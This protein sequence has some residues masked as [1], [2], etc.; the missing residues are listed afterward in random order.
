MAG[1]DAIAVVF[2]V[3]GTGGDALVVLEAW[4]AA[5][6][7]CIATRFALGEAAKG[8]TS[9]GSIAEQAEF[10]A[11]A[12]MFA[13]CSHACSRTF[14]DRALGGIARHTRKTTRAFAR[15]AS[16]GAFERSASLFVADKAQGKA[17]AIVCT[18]NSGASG[19]CP[20]FVYAGLSDKTA[21]GIFTR[22]TL[23][24]AIHVRAEAID[25]ALAGFVAIAIVGTRQRPL[26]FGDVRRGVGLCDL[27]GS[28]FLEASVCCD[29]G[30]CLGGCFGG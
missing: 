20:A 27:I 10:Q 29:L 26:F 7:R 6:A 15:L 4:I 11:I 14:A 24:D 8:A 30:G 2:A 22:R 9:V 5:Y 23:V 19:E 1:F 17:I 13:R 28:V 12:V 25:A 18:R 16:V 3:G 21:F